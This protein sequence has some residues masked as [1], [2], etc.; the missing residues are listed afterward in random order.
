M[1]ARNTHPPRGGRGL[2]GRLQHLRTV[3]DWLQARI[4]AETAKP[5]PDSLNI[6][7]MKRLR[8]KTK[9]EIALVSGI[10]SGVSPNHPPLSA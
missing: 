7:E 8:L 5:L 1:L 2:A 6:Q 3:H 9:D 10:A 4:D